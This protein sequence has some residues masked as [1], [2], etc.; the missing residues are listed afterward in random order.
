[1]RL[2]KTLERFRAIIAEVSDERNSEEGYWVYLKPGLWSPDDETHCVHEDR[3]GDIADK[4]KY[5]ER[6]PCCPGDVPPEG[7]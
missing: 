7:Y 3:I 5:V 4:L 2:P 1:M 6:C